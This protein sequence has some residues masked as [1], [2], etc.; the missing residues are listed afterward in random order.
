MRSKSID[1]HQLFDVR[2]VRVLVASVKDC[3]AAL[4]VVH[5]LWPH[6]PREFDDY[7]ANPKGNRYQSLHTA[8]VGPG[9]RTLEVQIRTHA[10]HQHAELGVAAH[11]QYKEGGRID[12]AFSDRVAWLRQ[13]LEVQDE[14]AE[15]GDFLDRFKTEVFHDRVYVLTP[16]GQVIDL[17]RG[18]TPLDFAYAVHTEVGH[19][20]RGAKV[21]GAMVPLTYELQSGDQVE[22]LTARQGGPSR[23]WLN[24]SLGFLKTSRARG[25]VRQWFKLQDFDKCVAA[26]RD[27]LERDLRRLGVGD[28]GL[29]R[30]AQRLR[31]TRVEDLLAAIGRGE[32]GTAQ[33]AGALQDVVLPAPPV[34]ERKARPPRAGGEGGDV[35]VEGVGNLMTHMARCCKPVPPDS[36]VGYITLGRGVTVHRQDCQSLLRLAG[37]D[38]TRLL[39]VSWS[40]GGDRTY[41][42]DVHI[43]AYDRQGLLRDITQ[44]LATERVNVSSV[45]TL[46][47]RDTRVARMR[48][49]LE[50]PD[51]DR[52]ARVLVRLGQVH[53]VTDVRRG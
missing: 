39:D 28:V 53:N 26:G 46:T 31:F 35:T 16:R 51:A 36:I 24:Q 44:V 21:R 34:T 14:G 25:K 48:L 30:L 8:V 11:W 7:I 13:L 5:S 17:P 52:L 47:D 9:G 12:T 27:E 38:G 1:F 20:C 40:T 6:I 50:V 18:A 3:Y 4:G 41:P 43:E 32:V 45:N 2:A 42:V 49:T 29:E 22:V 19:R 10:M 15:A 37:R 33:I 23:D